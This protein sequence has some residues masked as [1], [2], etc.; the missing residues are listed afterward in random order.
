MRTRR[1]YNV[2][3]AAAVAA[4]GAGALGLVAAGMLDERFGPAFQALTVF[5]VL[6]AGVLHVAADDH[7]HT[8]VG[9]ANYVTA[10][11]AALVA[12]IAG[13]VGYPAT[14]GDLWTLLLLAILASALDGVDGWLARRTRMTSVFGA[15]FDMET[16]AL[17]ILVLAVLVWQHDKAGAWVLACGLMRYGFVAAGWFWPG[18]ARPLRSTWRGKAV[19]VGQTLG[20]S[21]ALAPMLPGRLSALVAACALAALTWSF[22][23]D[24]RWLW[25]QSQGDHQRTTLPGS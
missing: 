24:I 17:L 4:G 16:D 12:V 19:A 3:V 5:A 15:R 11:R 14:P 21:M 1:R 13:A 18:L 6:F 22:A 25:R 7:P 23:L 9:P 20:L 8:R 10:A 2:G